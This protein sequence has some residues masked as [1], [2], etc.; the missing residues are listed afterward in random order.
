MMISIE[1]SGFDP[2]FEIFKHKNMHG[3]LFQSACWADLKCAW[4]RQVISVRR[5]GV[6]VGG[7]S[8]LLRRIPFTPWKLLYAPRGPVCDPSDIE[9]LSSITRGIRELAKREHGYLFKADPDVLLNDDAFQK[10][11]ASL[12]YRLLPETWAFERI[13]PQH[14]SACSCRYCR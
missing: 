3:S 9:T 1:I 2:E 4:K 12:G 11:M 10:S 13:Q 5:D 8:V 14:P 6:L 7:V